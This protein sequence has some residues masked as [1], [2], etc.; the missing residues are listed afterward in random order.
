MTDGRVTAIRRFP[1][2]GLGP[3]TL[4]SVALAPG[5]PFPLDRAWAIENGPSGFDPAAPER[6][7]KLK[8]LMLMRHPRLAALETRFSAEGR[9]LELRGDGGITVRGALGEAAGRTAIDR[10][11]AEHMAQDLRGAPRIVTAESH[12]FSDTGLPLISLIAR[13]SVE[14]LAR[15]AGRPVSPLRFRGN[16]EIEGLAP[17]QEFDLVNQELALGAELTVRVVEPIQRCA[18]TTVDPGTGAPDLDI[19][20]L[21]DRSFGHRRFGVYA[22]VVRGGRIGPG[23]AVRRADPAGARTPPF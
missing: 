22:E 5:T 13:E 7:S 10:F 18:A 14:A 20:A 16:V 11:L 21:L 12:T 23:D 2:K 15:L 6:L 19:P 9:V 3:E 8:F 1:V 4:D 17:W